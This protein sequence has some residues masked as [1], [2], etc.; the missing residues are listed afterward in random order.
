VEFDPEDGEPDTRSDPFP[1]LVELCAVAEVDEADAEAEAE[2]DVE[3]GAEPVEVTVTV[4]VMWTVV[5][6]TFP[7][8]VILPV[9][10]VGAPKGDNSAGAPLVEE[11]APAL[12]AWVATT[13]MPAPA[14]RTRARTETTESF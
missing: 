2:A 5:S 1:E 12:K 11:G 14:R 10:P 13:T 4:E 8:L 9:S 3:F 7:V 6:D